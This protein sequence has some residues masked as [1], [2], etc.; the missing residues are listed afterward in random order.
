MEETLDP[1]DWEA[2][3]ARLKLKF[4][5]S[6]KYLPLPE[7]K[8]EK[9]Q[10]GIICLGSASFPVIEAIDIL[11]ETGVSLDYMRIKALPFHDEVSDF[12]KSHEK[13]FVVELNRD[14]QLSQLLTLLIPDE[15][16]KLVKIAKIDG[17]PLSAKWISNE[18]LKSEEK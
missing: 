4:K 13:I 7:I 2:S 5:K 16:K 6:G 15:S 8:S 12:I 17:L 3:M 1:Q 14:G 11:K 18:I 10:F 9:N